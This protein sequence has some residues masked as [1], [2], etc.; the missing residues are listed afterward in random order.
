MPETASDHR[1]MFSMAHC[2]GNNAHHAAP[3]VP[4]EDFFS[5]IMRLQAGRI[6]D[7]RSALPVKPPSKKEKHSTSAPSTSGQNN[8]K[9]SGTSSKTSSIRS[10]LKSVKGSLKR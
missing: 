2:N 8:T 1:N 9:S 7:Q 6:E 4:D 10:S 5:L 3:T